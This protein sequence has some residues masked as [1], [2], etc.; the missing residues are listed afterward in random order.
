MPR[1]GGV[2]AILA[3]AG[4]PE[5]ALPLSKAADFFRDAMGPARVEVHV[6][7]D[8]VSL[9]PED[10]DRALADLG[11]EMERQA[12]AVLRA[13]PGSRHRRTI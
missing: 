5:L 3:E 13:L 10:R 8:R 12:Q 2:P 4:E 7:I 1:P 6:Q 9:L 11:R